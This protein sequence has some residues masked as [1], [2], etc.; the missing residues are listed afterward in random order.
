MEYADQTLAQLLPRRALTDAEAREMLMPVLDAL[1]FLHE[2]D[3]V[4]GQLKPANV[5]V[6]GDQLKLASDTVRRTGER[7]PSGHAPSLYD[8][9]EAL[10]GTG[11][12]AG[13]IWG[14][15]VT[16][17]EALTR[18]RPSTMG[19]RGDALVLP[20]DLSPAFRD[21]AAR[22]L[23]LRPQDRP[24][25]PELVAWA[26]GHSVSPVPVAS[27]QPAAAVQPESR[28]AEPH[29]HQTAPV[30]VAAEATPPVQVSAEATPPVQVSAD[31]TPPVRISADAVR[32]VSALSPL[33]KVRTQIAVMLG[34]VLIVTLAWAG[35]HLLGTHSTSAAR[36]A[37]QS[38][39]ALP[40]ATSG[41]IGPAAAAMRAHGS[42]NSG[43]VERGSS[44]PGSP[45]AL[46]EVI[47]E[48]PHSALRTIR[49]HIK[50]WV[51]I[52]V[53][54][55]G[56]VLAADVDRPGPSRYFQRL[57]L[58]AAKQWTFPTVAASPRRLMQIRFDFSR[59]GARGQAVAL[60][61]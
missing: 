49:G 25:V 18:R 30:R 19:G 46:R 13:D 22:C 15:G 24:G 31:T 57:A 28:A 29:V 51:R 33:S 54:E 23:S 12:P 52:I 42:G 61:P 60:K 44:A 50:V 17:C 38:S 48:V 34:P 7:R 37:V 14:L 39:G 6:V 32:P 21:L 5:L 41:A 59:D 53:D 56:S 43:I 35:W 16:V 58:R 26:R 1:E 11:S 4:H 40:A 20:P 3:L 27:P 55:D 9:P 10:P 8:P 2:R 36:L 47:P 45:N